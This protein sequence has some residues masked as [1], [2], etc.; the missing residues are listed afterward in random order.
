MESVLSALLIKSPFE[1]AIDWLI[2][3]EGLCF[4]PPVVPRKTYD[5][6]SRDFLYGRVPWMRADDP[7]HPVLMRGAKFVRRN[8]WTRRGYASLV[9][10]RWLRLSRAT[11]LDHKAATARVHRFID[12]SKGKDIYSGD[13]DY[14][15]ARAYRNGGGVHN[16]YIGG[17]SAE[18]TEDQ[19][20]RIHRLHDI[21]R[22]TR[23]LDARIE[24]AR[25]EHARKW[26]DLSEQAYLAHRAR[27]KA[28]HLRQA[29]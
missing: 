16:C 23:K 24:A 22:K 29:A 9:F 17:R 14:L 6:I 19:Y 11:V 2:R 8:N 7:E 10:E 5:S 28:G 26:H 20:G 25:K 27:S 1:A 12:L 18:L 3:N 15:C 4:N 21:V 13:F